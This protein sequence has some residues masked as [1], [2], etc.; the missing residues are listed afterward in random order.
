MYVL[1]MYIYAGCGG[2]INNYESL[3]DCQAV[4]IKG[5]CCFRQYSV[6]AQDVLIS[7]QNETFGCKVLGVMPFFD[8]ANEL[9]TEQL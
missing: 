5:A 7:S 4:A 6:R 1:S 3:Q 8:R 2:N 9:F